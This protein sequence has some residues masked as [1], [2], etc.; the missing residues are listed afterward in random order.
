MEKTVC[1]DNR[2]PDSVCNQQLF[3]KGKDSDG[4]ICKN[5]FQK[6]LRIR[7]KEKILCKDTNIQSSRQNQIL[8]WMVKSKVCKNKVDSK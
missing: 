5:S 1:T 6:N 4:Y 3:Q 8:F 7:K 2:I